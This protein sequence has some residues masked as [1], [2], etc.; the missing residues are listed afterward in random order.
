[1]ANR[2]FVSA[3]NGDFQAYGFDSTRYAREDRDWNSDLGAVFGA[4]ALNNTIVVGHIESGSSKISF[5][6]GSFNRESSKDFN[7]NSGAYRGVALSP[8]RIIALNQVPDRI[9]FYGYDGTYY[10]SENINLPDGTYGGLIRT[11]D[12]YILTLLTDSPRTAWLRFYTFAGSEQTAERKTLS[13][14]NFY[15]TL[16]MSDTR[17]FAIRDGT[18]LAYDFSRNRQSADDLTGLPSSSQASFT[19]F[20]QPSATLTI[21]TDDTD[22][23]AGETV[24]I[25]IASD[26]DI[27][28]FANTDITVTG[29][30]RGALTRTDA[31]NYVLSVTAGSAGTMTV[32]I[33]ANVVTPGNA[34][35]SQNFTV[36]AAPTP[37]ANLVVTISGT[38]NINQGQ[39]TTLTAAVEDAD[40]TAITSG[41]E[42]A[43]T[44]SRGRFIGSTTGASVVYEANFTDSSD[45]GVTISCAV[46]QPAN[47][48]PTSS[49]PSL[50]A[51][52][53]I[54]ITGQL[55]NMYMTALGAVGS[56]R[57]NILWNSSTGTLA[58]GSDRQIKSD[59]SIR[60]L[61]WAND[62]NRFITNGEGGASIGDYFSG[63]TNQ[64][65]YII[66]EGGTYVE[67]PSSNLASGG[68]GFAQFNVTDSAIRTLLN[69]LQTTSDLTVGIADAGSIG[70]DADSGT[71]TATVTAAA[72]VARPVY[73][74]PSAQSVNEGGSYS[75]DLDDVFSGAMSYSLQT[76][77]ESYVG[78]SGSVVSFTA[79]QVN[80]DTNIN[81]LVRAT[82]AGGNTDASIRVTIRQVPVLPTWTAPTSQAVNE[83][84]V[85]RIDLAD[86]STRATGYALQGTNE[87]YVGISG[88]VVSFTAPDV[89]EDTTITIN[90]RLSNIDGHID[91]SFSVLIRYV[92]PPLVATTLSRVSGSGQS[93]QVGNVLVNPLVVQVDDQNGNPLS[94]VSVA[95]STT[96]G[97][98]SSPSATTGANGRAS[99]TLTLPNTAGDVTVTASVAGLTDV[100][101]T[102]TA[103]RAPLP[104]PSI[105][106]S[107]SV[108][109]GDRG[110]IDLSWTASTGTVSQ[111]QFRRATSSAGLA[112]ATWNNAGTGTSYS[113]TNLSDSTTYYYQLRAINSDAASAATSA[114]SATTI[115]EPLVATTLAIVSGN[116]QS[117]EVGTAL[118]NPLVVRVNDQNGD[119]IAGVSVAFAMT[120]G[121]LSSAS[122]TTGSNGRASVTLT[123]PA[124]EGAV[125]V[126]ASVSGLA[127]VMFT[128]TAVAPLPIV[129]PVVSISYD[130]ASLVN[131]ATATA[132]ITTDRAGTG[133]AASEISVNVGSLA[134]FRE[135]VAGREWKVDVTAPSMGAGILTLTVAG[136]AFAEGNLA[137]EAS[138]AYA[139][140]SVAFLAEA[141]FT[142]TGVEAVI[143][144][145]GGATSGVQV[146]DLSVNAGELQH[147]SEVSNQEW[148]VYAVPPPTG[149]GTLTLTL[150]VPNSVAEV[151]DSIDYAPF[152]AQQQQVAVGDTLKVRARSR[153]GYFQDHTFALSVFPRR[154]D[155]PVE[156]DRTRE[157]VEIEG[158]DISRYVLEPGV[159]F[160]NSLDLVQLN[161]YRV[162]DCNIQLS[163]E[164]GY[165]RNDV[166]NNFWEANALHPSGYL[167]KVEV[168][169]EFLINGTW[170]SFLFFQGQITG[171]QNPL[172]RASTLRCFSNTSRLTQFE[173]ERSGVG[174]EKIAELTTADAASLVPVVEGTYSPEAGLSP[175]TAGT[176]TEAYHHQDALVLK[177]VVN[178][179]LGVK[180]NTGYLSASDLKT[181]GGVLEDPLL[182]NF[183]TGYRYRS[184]RDAFEKLTKIGGN[185]TSFYPDFEDLPLVEPHISVRGNIQFNTEYGRITRLPVDWIYDGA[186]KRLYVLLSN[187]SSHIADQL[188]MRQLD[189]ESSHVLR[190]FEPSL[191]VYRLASADYDTFYVLAGT[192]TDLDRSD[193]ESEDSEAFAL[194][195]DSSEPEA[196]IQV[197]KYVRSED[198]VETWID[199][200]NTPYTPQLGVH[201][202]VGFGNRD[203]AWQG[204]AP[205]R[206]SAFLIHNGNVYYRYATSTEFGVA[207]ADSNRNITQLFAVVKDGYA[208]HLNFAFCL[209][210]DNNTYFAYVEGTP[211]RSTLVIEK[212]DGTEK[213]E[214]VRIHRGI[215]ELD[216]VDEDAGAFLG[217]HEMIFSGDFLYMS[218]P[219]VC[220]NRDVD[221]TAMSVLYRYGLRT[222]VLE[223]LE[224]SD[225]VHF[226]F[227]GLIEHTETGDS[228]Y[229]KA[230]YYVQAPAEVYKY[231]AYNP[232]LPSYDGE[233]NHLP[234]FR[235]NLKRVLPTG[236]VEDAGTIRFDAEGA[237]RGLLCRNL[238]FDD[239]LQLM[240]AQGRP[241]TVEQRESVVS[242]PSG[243]LWCEFGRKLNFTLDRVPASGTLDAA[244]SK[245]AAQVNATFGVD[246]N[247]TILENRTPIGAIVDNT[248]TETNTALNFRDLN[249][250]RTPDD[251]F[252]LIDHE[253]IAYTGVVGNQLTGLSRGQAKTVPSVHVEYAEITFLADVIERDDTVGTDIS[254]KVDTAHLYNTIKDE[255]ELIK[256]KDELSLFNEKLL[257]LNMDLDALRIP[258][259]EFVAGNYLHRFKDLRFL[260]TLSVVPAY[261]L[262]I[263]DVVGFNYA[264]P[265]PPMAM[266]IM[267]AT[268]GT[269]RTEIVG[270]EVRPD[271]DVFIETVVEDEDETYRIVDLSE[272][273]VLVDGAGEHAIFGG[274]KR[275]IEPIPMTLNAEIADM[276]LTQYEA[277]GP[278]KMPAGRYGGGGYT[279]SMVGIPE[280]TYFNSRTRE[281]YGAPDDAQAATEAT[282][283]VTDRNGI[284][285]RVGFQ[286]T[287]NAV[288]RDVLRVLDGSGDPVL[289]DGAGNAAVFGL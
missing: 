155:I 268:Y 238:V 278:I 107:F 274:S 85:Y 184:V 41:L 286:I 128:A 253:L 106:G 219:V 73:T 132:T 77:N 52:S 9:E 160:Q 104:A 188:V 19:T 273:P 12:R 247:V 129:S 220:G 23:R 43:W 185:L 189:T 114:E 49:G 92:P 60:Q 79:P 198:W 276:V 120:G 82:N 64:S 72:V 78:I 112:S 209:D 226:G 176:E 50:T 140:F 194:G 105:P 51:L 203:F 97:T 200:E 147:F 148:R 102:A 138:I 282:Y 15:F 149:E 89:T 229:E 263:G 152:A 34:A 213:T 96:G 236:E 20:E 14:G 262:K 76:G 251:G 280:N 130:V 68:T 80:T 158:I 10:P 180:D 62:I 100:T 190:E 249:R 153:D 212:S 265:I 108:A 270:R 27:T 197:L 17:F 131:G 243:A 167:N 81:L 227:C 69:N 55:V 11:A 63:N 182:L 231:P 157:R 54:G 116:N 228:D 4:F 195:L 232:D 261:N 127:D 66:F 225:F 47:D 171:L 210:H 150:A 283:I 192:S 230:V 242:N 2:I 289:V 159:S 162:A 8:T 267:S 178:N 224:V 126:T 121:T 6:D 32:S 179:A 18:G 57:N 91:R 95:F 222:L 196:N 7:L 122:E 175:L 187:P 30:T 285:L 173:L 33:A 168:F 99:V 5:W 186:A 244:L 115:A 279:Y 204:N 39:R 246:R 259:I 217:V 142:K 146:A 3:A 87:A 145:T 98:L 75:L 221:K 260:L 124:T 193:P 237:F 36:N 257:T 245:M 144:A 42:Y 258:W 183:K 250:S 74:A 215:L 288:V 275:I 16:A 94:G 118:A 269:Q 40:G 113:D 216:D 166:P 38:T 239:A 137:A 235:G 223:K 44:A 29:G 207:Q 31:R 277:F 163:N 46:T 61:R 90:V 165:F 103:T 206:Y 25:D 172:A 84:N 240:V 287:V 125:T 214:I 255:N 174:I 254:W 211:F 109:A 53:E 88:S 191:A 264:S 119:P 169:V 156:S 58:A 136:N 164:A 22:I 151:S 248:I 252:V 234:E 218:V 111:Y 135:T 154:Q 123:M 201:Y 83:G 143:R 266:Q 1:M 71:G 59:L 45:V 177:E 141:A 139:P 161:K 181:Q 24:D 205:G 271:I 117:A 65:V 21:S 134:N 272:N 133:L 35:V 110:V 202:H 233:Q 13:S 67:I 37:A 281:F 28:E 86:Q 241:D 170:Q 93:A 199:K 256:I 26:I 284:K 48:S 208:N 56:N 70:I 101:F